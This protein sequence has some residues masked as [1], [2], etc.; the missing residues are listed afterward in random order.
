MS[1]P[2]AIL[3]DAQFGTID[4]I[5]FGL[6]LSFSTW[7]GIYYGFMAKRK[8]NTTTEYILGGKQMTLWPVAISLVVS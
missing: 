3:P 1:P 7:I 5:I 8:Q 6:L 2:R 4:Y